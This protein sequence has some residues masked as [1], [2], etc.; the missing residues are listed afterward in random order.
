MALG[1]FHLCL[2]SGC[3]DLK[4]ANQVQVVADPSSFKAF[5]LR[6]AEVVYGPYAM[7]A[8]DR[9][10]IIAWEEA[11]WN[12]KRRHVEVPF[13]GLDPS[14]RYYYSI[15]GVQETGR[16]LTAPA[17]DSPFTFLLWSDSRTGTDVAAE[18]AQQM[19][20]LAPDASFALHAG[21][22]VIDGD[23]EES[24]EEEWWA[25]MYDLL[26]HCPIYPTMGNHEE[27]SAF[28]YRYFSSLGGNGVN[29]SF[30]W[31]DAHFV[32]CK[33]DEGDN[34]QLAWLEEDLA[35]N[36][37]A[38]LTVVCHHVPPFSST[39][40]DTGGIP[41]LQDSVVP[42]FEKYGVDLVVSGDIHSY[43][44]HIRNNIH[45]LTSAGG[46]EKP[47][48]YGLP[49]EE[50][51][52]T[53]L[54]TYNFSGC[55]IENNTISITTYNQAGECIDSFEITPLN[56][57]LITSRV[58]VEAHES[59]INPGGQCRV[60]IYVNRVENLDAVS[61]TMQYAKDTPPVILEV[62]DAD[63][64][65]EGIQIEPGELGGTVQINRADNAGGSLEYRVDGINGLSGDK[66]KV[67]SAVFH[68]PEDAR[69]TA[70]Y[71]VPQVTLL[72]VTGSE[73]PHFMGGAKIVIARE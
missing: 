51:T 61:L 34:E 27:N 59:N 60:D 41:Y 13:D 72:D 31:G 21:D 18:I 63:A 42:L 12:G 37:N 62:I 71:L 67:A 3:Q 17:D 38:G 8:A 49:L 47:Y 56:P 54:K 28:Y 35:G 50:M 30:D 26:L 2:L 4:D 9:T 43:Q 1:L 69:I 25:P 15:N 55:S 66:M 73:I 10:A 36:K 20:M 48:D 5:H 19:I 58:T 40:S 29:Y 68:I 45:Y 24:W 33:I 39:T 44:H 11:A 57:S 70:M 65:V 23:R 53:L 46:G 6:P 22:F 64:A 16:I 32:V 14:T 7:V 52:L